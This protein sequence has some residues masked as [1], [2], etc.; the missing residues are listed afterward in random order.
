MEEKETMEAETAE[1]AKAEE[2]TEEQEDKLIAISYILFEARQYKPGDILPAHN[3]EMVD[4]WIE[5]GTAKWGNVEQKEVKAKPVT[6]KPG[7]TGSAVPRS[8]EDMAG[9]VPK[10]PGRKK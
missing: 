3:H 7:L 8:G 4:A 5:A 1:E 6:A 9:Q 2:Q 10:R